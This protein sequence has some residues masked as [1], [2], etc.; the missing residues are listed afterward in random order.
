MSIEIKLSKYIKESDKA[1]QILSERLGITIS[2]LDF[3]IALGSVLGYDDHDSTSVLEHEFTAEQMLEKLGN[4]E[5]NFPEEIASVTFEHSILPK[6]VP[7]R[8]DEEEIKNKGEIW[9]I[10]K[11]DKDPFPSDPHAHNKATGYKLHL[12]TGD[13][14]SNKNKPLDKKISKKY[15]IAIRDKVKNIALPDLLV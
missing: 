5:F 15:L 13:L 2:S 11:N 12:G 10:H 7:Q 4:Y 3:Q 9:V 1:R 8:L 14:Y 6:S